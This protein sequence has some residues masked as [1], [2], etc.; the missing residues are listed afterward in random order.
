MDTRQFGFLTFWLGLAGLLFLLWTWFDSK[1]HPL[2]FGHYG[3]KI[4][5]F[6]NRHAALQLSISN[7]PGPVTGFWL[8]GKSSPY[9][10]EIPSPNEEPP[11]RTFVP[12]G[13]GTFE[14]DDGRVWSVYWIPHWVVLAFY[15]VIWGALGTRNRRIYLR[16]RVANPA[17]DRA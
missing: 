10:D 7:N 9:G 12:P 6:S 14:A 8:R 13:R 15:L 5:V 16:H 2:D 17:P 1:S 11:G 3:S 4:H